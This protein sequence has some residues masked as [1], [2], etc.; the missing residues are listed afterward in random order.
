M[1]DKPLLAVVAGHLCLDIIPTISEGEAFEHAFAPGR[2]VEV[3]RATLATG[4]AV[5]NTGV[6]L[7]KLGVP[8]RLMGKV[9]DDNFGRT[10]LDLLGGFDTALV[11]QMI[12]SPGDPA[13]IPLW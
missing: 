8:T 6:A 3:G 12:V 2:L 13:P 11:G 1:Q 4:G 7:H 9:G 10:I 5:S